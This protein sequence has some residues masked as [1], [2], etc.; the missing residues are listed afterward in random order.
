MRG[1]FPGGFTHCTT[2]T[3]RDTEATDFQNLISELSGFQR[4][5]WLI[6]PEHPISLRRAKET[7][8]GILPVLEDGLP[9]CRSTDGQAGCA[10]FHHRLEACFTITWT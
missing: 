2:D 10:V 7:V 5:Q 1:K 8:L 9:A 4:P 6:S 3:L